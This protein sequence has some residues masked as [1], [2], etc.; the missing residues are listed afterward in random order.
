M[1]QQK[2][3]ELRK[4]IS[5]TVTDIKSMGGLKQNESDAKMGKNI[6][7]MIAAG[8]KADEMAKSY[9][10]QESKAT[11]KPESGSYL[12]YT[13]TRG[14]YVSS[15]S[16]KINSIGNL[17]G[18]TAF[19]PFYGK[20]EDCINLCN[21]TTG[22]QGFNIGNDKSKWKKTKSDG[23]NIYPCYFLKKKGCQLTSWSKYDNWQKN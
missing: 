15:S 18:Y 20:V 17:P 10:Q 19:S 2:D 16:C 22:C 13:P 7:N 1:Q 21:E 9:G 12:G 14:K 6:K 4:D 5:K 3:T 8:E 11:S 23:T